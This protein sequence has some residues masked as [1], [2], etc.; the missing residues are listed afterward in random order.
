M[1]YTCIVC[2]TL[3]NFIFIFNFFYT[4]IGNKLK[5]IIVTI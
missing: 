3:E 2:R 4:Y 1:M 5:E